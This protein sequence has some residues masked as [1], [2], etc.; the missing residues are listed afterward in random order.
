MPTKKIAV[1]KDTKSKDALLKEI[2]GKLTAALPELKEKIG[3]KKFDKRIK[4]VSKVLIAGIKKAPVKNAPAKI[5]KVI[6]AV[7]KA[8]KIVD[9]KVKGMAK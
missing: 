9:K 3:V 2:T 4:K 5:K 1:K 8:I 6:P 7:K